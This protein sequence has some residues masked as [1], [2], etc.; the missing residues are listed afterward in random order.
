V[1]SAPPRP[2]H[3]LIITIDTL[4]ADHLGSYGNR[5][6]ATP[7]IDR[8]ANEGAIADQAVV[9]APITRPSHISIFTGLYPSQHGIRDNLSRP[10]AQE[11]PTLAETFKKA[12]FRTA[13][14]ISSIVLSAQSGLGRGFDDFSDHF[15][16]G[17]D[18]A[19][20][21]RFLDILEKRGDVATSEAITWIL[22]H[23]AE[24]TFAWVHLYDPH[25]PYEPPEPYASRYA[26]RPYDGE[27]AWT[28]ELV[29]R[30]DTALTRSGIRD[31]TLTVLTSDHGESLGEHGEAVHGFF[32][33][34]ATLRVPLIVRGPGVTAGGHIR[35]L[36]RSIDLFPTLLDLTAVPSPEAAAFPRIGHSFASKI[37]GRDAERRA[38]ADLMAT[39]SASDEERELSFAESLTP[40]IHYG[41]SDLKSVSDGRWKYILAPKSELYDLSRDPGELTNLIDAEPTHARALRA[42]LTHHL[43]GET[44]PAGAISP[45]GPGSND[46]SPELVQ[47]LGA[48]GYVG[49]GGTVD[50]ASADADPK[51]KIGEYKILNALLH[52]GL[53]TLRDKDYAGA[54]A[55]FHE[56]HT[57]G[58]DSFEAHYY[59]GQALAGLRRWREAAAEFQRAIPR[60]PGFTASYLALAE[61]RL[62]SRDLTGAIGAL[63]AG[64]RA[65]PSDPRLYRR[66]GELTRN[67]GDLKG[68]EEYFRRAIAQDPEDASEWNSL[69]MLVGARGDMTEA[70]HDF[71]E[72]V[73]RDGREARYTYN[74]GLTLQ[75]E[76]R[77]ADAQEYFRKTLDLDPR[78]AAAR[79]RLAELKQ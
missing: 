56:L 16:L 67:A 25:A 57:R 49:V 18:A 59:Y 36:V 48:L 6:V 45:V 74:L 12:G 3:V 55:R 54:A 23:S 71:R 26:E 24:R 40:R 41:W 15:D 33:Y 75:R 14:F 70:E 30:L 44:V 21:G 1:R 58:I 39:A 17:A 28:D 37:T 42:A 78:F 52:E 50:K 32:L 73:R 10:L 29:G 38:A 53:L 11:V 43:A 35:E 2:A 66:L 65:V 27:V 61:C 4:R 68:A 9:Q 79:D 76:H 22:A 77:P 13:G 72:A 60:L 19:D 5:D 69:G 34:Q 46:V 62:A 7:N 51:D 47:R 8:L 20:E 64:E 63:H 31:Q